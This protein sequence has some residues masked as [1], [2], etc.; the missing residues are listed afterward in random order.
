MSSHV[1]KIIKQ[2]IF[3]ASYPGFY[4]PLFILQAIKAWGGLGTRLQFFSAQLLYDRRDVVYG[5][6]VAMHDECAKV[7]VWNY[8]ARRGNSTGWSS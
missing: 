5:H 6:M 2:A 4:C 1:W 3:L 8:V 7:R